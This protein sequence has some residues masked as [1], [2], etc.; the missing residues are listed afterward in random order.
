MPTDPYVAALLVL[1]GLAFLAT[2]VVVTA[3]LRAE[4]SDVVAV[5]RALPE[6]A[7]TLMRWRRRR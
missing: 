2:V 3:I 5:I 6:L 4:R 7:A 1:F